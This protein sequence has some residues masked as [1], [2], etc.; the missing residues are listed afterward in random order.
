[1]GMT[2]VRGIFGIHDTQSL[3]FRALFTLIPM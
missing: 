3:G 1:V 2:S